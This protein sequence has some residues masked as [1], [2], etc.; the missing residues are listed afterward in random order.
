VTDGAV[1]PWRRLRESVRDPLFYGGLTQTVKAAVAAVV[2][3]VL[4]THL[5][6]HSQ[7]FLAPWSAVLT[8]HATV[9]RSLSQGLRQVGASVLGVLVAFVFGDLIGFSSVTLGLAILVSLLIGRHP[10]FGDE[11][12][13]VA[14]TAL[15]VLTTGV[16]DD[17]ASL[18]TRLLDTAIGIVVG[19]LVNLLV[20]PPLQDRLAARRVAS[21]DERLGDLLSRMANEVRAG[22][23]REQAAD[24]IEDV[25][26]IDERIDDAWGLVRQARESARFNFRGRRIVRRRGRPLSD[27]LRRL[28]QAVA[29][30]RSMAGTLERHAKGSSAVWA[31]TFAAAWVN[32]LWDVGQA[33]SDAD[34][35]SFEALLWR[36]D[37]LSSDLVAE[38]G[39]RQPQWPVYGALLVNL[40]NITDSLDRVAEAH[41]IQVPGHVRRKVG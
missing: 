37:D 36:I 6:G 5:V 39:T 28:E 20:W 38:D 26:A 24:W 15:V 9:Y 7:A 2:A 35:E 13:T 23:T 11:G 21:I 33:V 3:W 1:R 18:G 4:A 29:E 10:R 22:H 16:G 41:P 14:T 17:S 27:V 19:V 12:V 40:R 30:T 31:D 34:T 8:V 25:N 32:L